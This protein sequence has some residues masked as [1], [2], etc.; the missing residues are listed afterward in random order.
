MRKQLDIVFLGLSLSSSWGNGHAT[1]FRGLLKGLHELGHHV[2]FL[3]RDVPW[4]ASH[5][6]LRDPDFCSLR[7][8]ET[9]NDLRGGLARCLRQ[10]DVIVVGSFVP[11]G[12]AIID[13]IASLCAGQ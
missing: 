7:Y 2:T 8:Y 12:Q 13:I 4:Y 3:E 1:T 6:D 5:R 11:E 10:A 9:T